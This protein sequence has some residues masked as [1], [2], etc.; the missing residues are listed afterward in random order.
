VD[1]QPHAVAAQ[2]DLQ[3]GGGAGGVL[4]GVRQRL[5]GDPHDRRAALRRELVDPRVD[6]GE[7][8]LAHPARVLD[9]PLQGPRAGP[10][11]TRGVV[12]GGAQRRQLLPGDVGRVVD[13]AEGLAG[14]LRIAPR[15][16]VDHPRLDRDQRE[17]VADDV[18]QLAGDVAALPVDGGLAEPVALRPHRRG[19]VAQCQRRPQV[20]ADRPS[21]RPGAE[22]HRDHVGV[23]Q[24]REVVLLGVPAEDGDRQG[25]R[26]GQ[27][28]RAKPPRPGSGVVGERA[29]DEDLGDRQRGD[30][31][32]LDPQHEEG[33]DDGDGQDRRAAAQQEAAG[34]QRGERVADRCR[35]R[36]GGDRQLLA[37]RGDRGEGQRRE[38]DPVGDAERGEA[39]HREDEARQVAQV[40]TGGEIARVPPRRA[41][42][43]DA[44]L[45]G[46]FPGQGVQQD[47]Q[48]VGRL[49]GGVGHPLPQPDGPRARLGERPAR[50]ADQRPDLVDEPL[51]HPHELAAEHA[52]LVVDGGAY[53]VRRPRV[54]GADLLPEP[55]DLV[56]AAAQRQPR[57]N[58]G[59][60]DRGQV[61][62]LG[63][64]DRLDPPEVEP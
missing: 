63:G 24:R 23:D 54:E 16:G 15:E 25:D 7:Y 32:E 47:A 9:D 56:L 18:V 11:G 5:L 30:L 38:L 12:E 59:E 33:G 53:F 57:Q 52:A 43:A 37:A 3:R 10:R 58:A 51:H 36:G 41:A 1:G 26:Q 40:E 60:G 2:V 27:E 61:E 46:R 62:V 50:L 14:A 8:R 20:L 49:A 48:L 45:R 4:A 13:D 17:A 21:H 34:R 42:G 29:A 55:L 28:R 64:R 19:A 39:G 31:V 6:V 44:R 22:Q 35:H